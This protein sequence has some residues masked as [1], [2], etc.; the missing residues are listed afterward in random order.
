MF[1][2]AILRPNRERFVDLF[3]NQG[4]QVHKYL[5]PRRLIVLFKKVRH[6]E[7]FQTVCWEGALGYGPVRK[8]FYSHTI[9]SIHILLLNTIIDGNVAL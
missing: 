4:F 7:F 9:T 8:Y 1:D 2:E 6:H 5:T 3:L